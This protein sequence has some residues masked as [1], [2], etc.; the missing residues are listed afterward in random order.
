M[1]LGGRLLV[2]A[3]ALGLLSV[4]LYAE[5]IQSVTVYRGLLLGL[6]LLILGGLEL[7]GAGVRREVEAQ[8]TATQ[9]DS[10]GRV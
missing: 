9:G 1:K 4:G 5:Q 7:Y 10:A 3:G 6:V 8:V 2:W